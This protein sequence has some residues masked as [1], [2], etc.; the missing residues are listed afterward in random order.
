MEH[1]ER[2]A[3]ELR[4]PEDKILTKGWV[5][6]RSGHDHSNLCLVTDSPRTAELERANLGND[7]I[8][9]AGVFG[10]SVRKSQGDKSDEALDFMDHGICVGHLAPVSHT[11]F[12]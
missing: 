7:I 1:Q 8:S 11:R 4:L 2:S 10:H 3:S 6:T 9:E 5:K 12:S